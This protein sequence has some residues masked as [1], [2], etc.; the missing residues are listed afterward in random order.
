MSIGLKFQAVFPCALDL[1]LEAL[2]QKIKKGSYAVVGLGL[3]GLAVI[4]FLLDQGCEVYALEESSEA[5]LEKARSTYQNRSVHFYWGNFSDDVFSKVSEIFVSPGVPLTRPWYF[6]AQG[7]VPVYGELELASRFLS[8]KI[9]AVTGT[10]GKSTTVSLIQEF[11]KEA[12]KSSSL[13]GNIGSPLITA[14]LEPPKD[15]YVV[16]VSSY[17]LETIQ[18]FRPMISVNLNV[19]PDHLER[20]AS[21]AE[22]AAAKEKIFSNQRDE[23][24]FIYNADDTACQDMAKKAGCRVLGFSLVNPQNPGAWVAGRE[25]KILWNQTES[26]YG[27]DDCAL[28][29]LHNQENMLAALLVGTVCGLS[30][31]AMKKA[32][33]HFSSLPHRV[34]KIGQYRGICFYDDSKGTNVGAVV[35]SLASFEKNVILILGGRDKGGDYKPLRGLMRYKVKALIVMGEAAELI[36]GALEGV[37]PVYRVASMQEAV[38]KSYELG[39]QGDTVLLSPACSSFDRYRNYVERGL[40]F[41]KCVKELA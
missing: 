24:V 36:A 37:C 35:M 33:S 10:N 22:Y 4:D 29:G 26:S 9:L 25:M 5:A 12:G 28:Q 11:L 6:K 14:L 18:N 21:M 2:S 40:D 1:T 13:K 27:L 7:Q 16:E 32:L 20:Y 17:Q 39:T 15:Y 23:D 8:G 19:T 41:Q 38:Q 3:T 30:P 31:L 34:Q